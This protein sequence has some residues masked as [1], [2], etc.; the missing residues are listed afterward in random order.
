MIRKFARP[1]LASVYVAD[2]VDVVLNSQ[3]H[4]E[5]TQAV[6]NRLHTVVPRKYMK[7]L[8]EDPQV[9]TQAV[10][11]TKVLAG[12][13][14]ALGK[15]PRTS[16]T[17][18]AA[19]SVP[20][21]IAR[22]AFWETQ[23]REEKIARRQGFL[24][25]I[26]LLGGLAITSA[27]TAGKPGL[28]WRADKAAQKASTQIQQALPTKSETKKFGDQASTV[29]NQ[30]ASAAKDLAKDLW[31]EATD[32][33]SEYSQTAQDYLEDN[34][35]DWLA[36]AQKNAILAKK[37]AVK[38]AA[39]AQERAAQAYESAEK[40]TGRSAKRASKKANQ[41]QRK[42]EKSLNKAMKRFDSAF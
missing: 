12:S 27:D 15:A 32:A 28:K 22:H 31:N 11:A 8:P 17:V 25:S 9:I 6:I 39:R 13:S 33:V 10:G 37:K 21:I 2:G 4:V 36:L 23:D 20:T 16:A 34:K 42:A 18:L 26:A 3:A 38:V 14:L 30:T 1:M 35:D 5:G 19:I 7:K 41:L 40:S 29:A 24:T